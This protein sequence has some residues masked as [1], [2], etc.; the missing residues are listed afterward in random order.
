MLRQTIIFIIGCLYWCCIN[1]QN[2]PIHIIPEPAEIQ[3]NQGI[4][5][6]LDKHTS[7]QFDKK[8]QKTASYF[9][10]YLHHYYNIHPSV[11]NI[12]A[13]YKIILQLS[14][15]NDISDH[16]EGYHLLNNGYEIKIVSKTEKGIF[17]G[18]QTLI[19]LISPEKKN[20]LSIPQVVIKD[21]PRFAYRGLHLDVSRHM[22]PVSYIKRYID[23]LA[24]HKLN[25]FHWHLTDDQGWRIEIKQLPKLMS[26]GAWREGT[27]IGLFPGK[28]LDSTRYGGYYTQEEVKEIIAYA[29]SRYVEII[30]EIDIPAHNMATIAAYPEL[31]TTP[32]IPKKV[33]VTWGIYNRQNNVLAPSAKT[34][35]FLKIVFDEIS[36]LFP[37]KYIHIGGDEAAK[38]WWKQSPESQQFMKEHG[39]KDEDELQSYFIK[40]V[41]KMI[42]EKGKIIIGWDE[43]LEGGI[44]PNAI[45]MSWRGEKGG[46]TAANMNHKVIMCP[47]EY[48]YFDLTQQKDDDSIVAIRSITPWQKVYAYDPVPKELKKDKETFIWGA[49]ANVWTEYINNSSKLEYMVLPRLAAFSEVVWSPLSKRD[50]D[51]FESKLWTQFHRYDLWKYNYYRI[52]R[53]TKSES[54]Q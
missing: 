28:G 44:A 7:I 53:Q 14:D 29:E 10:D 1:A 48:L 26:V 6:I 50:I 30:P 38:Q 46:I 54:T 33:A 35:D 45:L 19:Q 43:I 49:Q 2:Q 51:Q 47:Q 20:S 34:F 12:Q 42:H 36:Q 37:S 21:Y 31:S 9:T 8:L 24:F 16:E 25:Y 3:I 22:F 39:L 18:L 23:L 27:I 52:K 32:D 11:N 4:S 41:Q 5:F 15:L 13:T 17:Y 40:E